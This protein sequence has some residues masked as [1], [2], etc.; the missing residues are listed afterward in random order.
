MLDLM[1]FSTDKEKSAKTISCITE[2]ASFKNGLITV[3]Y[4]DLNGDAESDEIFKSTDNKIVYCNVNE[5]TT[6]EA[7]NYALEISNGDYISFVTND[8]VYQKNSF[9]KAFKALEKSDIVSFN[10]IYFNGETV[11]PYMGFELCF[12]KTGMTEIDLFAFPEKFH[13]CLSAYIFKKSLFDNV[14]FDERMEYDS[15]WKAVCEILDTSKKYTVINKEY[16]YTEPDENDYFNYQ[17]QF[18]KEW[19]L[20]TMD[21]FLIDAVKPGDSRFKQ[22]FVLYMTVCRYA[23]NMNERDKTILSPDEADEFIQKTTNVLRNIEDVIICNNALNGKGRAPAFFSLNLLRMKYNDP[24]LMPQIVSS[25]KNLAAYYK[26]SLLWTLGSSKLEFKVLYFDGKNLTM[27]GFFPGIYVFDP[28]EIEI[29]AMLNQSKEYPVRRN[30]IYALNK[31]FNISAKGNYTFQFSI[32]EAELSDNMT[33][34]F[35]LKY[36]GRYYALPVTFIRAQTKLSGV[37]NSYWVFGNHILTYKSKTKEFVVETLTRKRLI[38]HELSFIKSISAATHGMWKLKM[39]GNR[40]LYWLTKPFYRKKIWLTMDKLFK[41]GDNGEYFYRYAKKIN[42]KGIR[43]Y[44]VVQKDSPDYKRLKKEYNT[45]VKFNSIHHKMLALHTDLM[46]ATHVDTM[47]CNGYYAATQKYFKD[48][49]NA[50]VVCLAHGLT[51]Q[52]IA[53]YQNR[54]FDNTVLYFFASKYEVENVSHEI[55]DYYDKNALQLT[56]HARYDG[57]VNNDKKIILI[58]PTW[59]RGITTGKAKKGSTYAHSS[60]F[61]NSE[62]YKIYNGLITDKRL[63]DTANAHGYKI[64]YLLHPAMSAQLE[65]FEQ[66]DGVDVVAA[67]SDISYEKILTESSL[68]VTDYSGVQFDFAYMKKPLVYYHPDSLPPQYEAGGL[69]YETMGFGPI[70]KNHEEIISSLC[71]Y[72]ENHC[73]MED[74]YKERVDDFFRYSDHNNCAR[75]YD[76]VIEF[77]NKFDKV[78]KHNYKTEV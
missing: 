18:N 6:P 28:N 1:L 49:Y 75:I 7:F 13:L 10:P 30:H 58:T 40:L 62:Y 53:Q 60:S 66:T 77:Q 46:L 43:I 65:D 51:I 9:K 47:N 8:G 32:P 38:K 52:R 41:A 55:Y 34:S 19:Y 11:Q 23:C 16:T 64:V 17:P 22:R 76:K 73:A 56:G 4:M 68:M 2:D 15:E 33:I 69:V 36:Q 24:H 5:K 12:D 29:V 42:P 74:I 63:I 57:L 27:D 61:K 70:C 71:K 54:V 50:R 26:D 59:R 48:L 45:I 14:T 67:T 3:Y 31:F 44:Y 25:G 20:D 78:N 72:I 35:Y 37:K 21:Y 39:V